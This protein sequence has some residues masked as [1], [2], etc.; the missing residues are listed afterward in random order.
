MQLTKENLKITAIK[1]SNNLGTYSIEP[2]PTG[3]GYSLANSL[4]R[5]ILT[6]TKGAAVTQIKITGANHQFTT[7]PGIKEDIVEL[8]MNLKKIRCRTFSDNPVIATLKKKGT[9]EVKAKDIEVT[10]EIEIMNKDLHIATLSDSKSEINIE[11][12]I[13]PGTGYSPME[14]R[15]TSKIGV[16]VLDALFSPIINANYEIEPARFGGKIDLD[17]IIFTVETD[18]SIAPKQAILDAAQTLK[19]YYETLIKWNTGSS[20]SDKKD[21]KKEDPIKISSE[22]VSIEE[23][24][25]QTRTINALKKQ[26]INTLHELSEKTDEDI[27]DIKNLGEKSLEEIKKLLEKEGL[28]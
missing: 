10:S 24:P 5:V 9:G 3:F 25:L 17:R 16:I 13:E 6:S 21:T 19:E 15:Q 4:R 1:E 14:E 11:L 20:D 22:D 26:G 28:R 12:T 18:G 2:L 8:T 23:L 7:L 27:A